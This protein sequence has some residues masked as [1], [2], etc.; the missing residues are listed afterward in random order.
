VEVYRGNF[1]SRRKIGCY[2]L[3]PHLSTCYSTPA[4]TLQLETKNLLTF[5]CMH[6]FHDGLAFHTF[7]LF[8]G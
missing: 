1:A 7:T 4:W 6:F 3:L 2:Y 8:S 5:S